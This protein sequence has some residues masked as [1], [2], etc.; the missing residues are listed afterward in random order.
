MQNTFPLPRAFGPLL[1]TLLALALN[2]CGKAKPAGGVGAGGPDPQ[3]AA[4]AQAVSNRVAAIVANGEPINPE[5]LNRWYAEAPAGRNAAVFY[6]LA[7]DALTPTR[8]SNEAKTPAYLARNQKALQLLL[9]AAQY[10]DCRYPIDLSEGAA[11]KLPHLSKAKL[12]CFLLQS[13]AVSQAALGH[14]DTATQA[15][16]ADLALARSLQNE[17]VAIS[18]LVQCACWAITA[19]GM[20]E[21]LTRR[22]FTEEQ[23]KSLQGAVREALGA[24]SCR[25][26]LVGERAMDLALYQMSLDPLTN[27]LQ[28]D[29]AQLAQLKAY[30]N[31]VT[32]QQDFAFALDYFS[33]ALA[34]AALPFPQGL[35]LQTLQG[36]PN[37]ETAKTQGYQLAALLLPAMGNLPV[38]A[39]QA[40]AWLRTAQTGLAVESYRLTHHNALPAS[41]AELAP[42]CLEAVPADPFDGQPLRYKKL[43]GKGYVIY[44]LGKD[45]KD[46][47]GTAKSADG[48]ELDITFTVQR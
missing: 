24:A 31:T 10:K 26:A 28:G 5:E 30:K 46:D 7:F 4:A 39:G 23:M 40:A 25:R 16:L 34:V 17:P 13:Q 6:G 11:T 14:T 36:I 3:V 44:S 12:A 35:D 29:Q 32:F 47:H 21:A 18:W 43:P 1:L 33:N 37:P 48:K 9:Q 2:G 15:L 42:E 22:A 27:L 45:R 41:L 8:D 20:A 19:Q 38:K